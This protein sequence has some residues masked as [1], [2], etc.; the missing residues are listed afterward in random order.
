VCVAPDRQFLDEFKCV[1]PIAD[2]VVIDDEY[3]ALPAQFAQTVQFGN[4]L[5]RPLGS[6]LAAIDR[7]DVAE[8]ALEWA[9]TR[10]LHG[11]GSVFV[12]AEQVEP[13]NRATGYVRLVCD[14]VHTLGGPVFQRLRNTG[15]D[16]FRLTHH[17]VVGFRAHRIGLA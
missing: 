13:G 4:E 3:L 14:P 15:E 11:H 7:D 8:L 16:L 10:K 12:H 1:L 9:A 6:W 5:S 17:H 2:E